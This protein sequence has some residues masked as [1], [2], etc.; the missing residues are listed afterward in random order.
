[1]R[2]EEVTC[3]IVSSSA[4]RATSDHDAALCAAVRIAYL[5]KPRCRTDWGPH[6]A[7]QRSCLTPLNEGGLMARTRNRSDEGSFRNETVQN[8]VGGIVL[9]LFLCVFLFVFTVSH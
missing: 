2:C 8:I 5:V 1:M 3:W 7:G 4:H 6:G 9:P